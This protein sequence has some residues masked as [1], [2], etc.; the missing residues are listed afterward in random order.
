VLYF[1]RFKT[2][3]RTCKLL[4]SCTDPYFNRNKV[5]DI[6]PLKRKLI[7]PFYIIINKLNDATSDETK[8]KNNSV[9]Q[10]YLYHCQKAVH[11]MTFDFVHR[12][13]IIFSS[14]VSFLEDVKL[15]LNDEISGVNSEIRRLMQ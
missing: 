12:L 9:I 2:I 13:P 4:V 3:R 6:P 5:G 1:V 8:S 11:T 15:N 7:D 10:I 14:T